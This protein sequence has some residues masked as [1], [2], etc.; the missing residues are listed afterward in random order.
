M[1]RVQLA[2]LVGWA[3]RLKSRKRLQKVAYLLQMM[4]CSLDAEFT[5]HHFG[6]YSFDLAQLTD[7]MACAGLLAE[8]PE[9]QR[10]GSRYDYELTDKA[11]A[12]LKDLQDH[13]DVKKMAPFE[14]KAKDLLKENLRTLEYAATLAYFHRGQRTLDEAKQAAAAF[15]KLPPE[16]AEMTKAEEL[17]QSLRRSA[18]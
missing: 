15:K 3:G 14:E 2:T 7:E 12:Q 9:P 1:N 8:H 13:D 10:V 16:G 4:G 11:K 6:P 17:Y 5:L 18:S